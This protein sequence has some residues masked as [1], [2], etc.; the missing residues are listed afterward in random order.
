MNSFSTFPRP[1]VRLSVANGGAS[2]RFDIRALRAGDWPAVNALLK[3]AWFPERSE[4]GWRWLLHG[5]GADPGWILED[6]QGVCGVVGNFLQR[7]H[8]GGETLAAAT[9]HSLVVL[10]RARGGS[11]PLID[12]YSTQ[13]GGRSTFHLNA[14]ALSAPLYRKFG[15]AP[16]PAPTADVKL[17]WHA[18][19]GDLVVERLA[20]K[21]TP[22]SAK[23]GREW[24]AH[25]RYCE[26]TEPLA[27]APQVRGLRPPQ[28]L[29]AMDALFR[30]AVAEG[31]IL[32]ARDADTLAW[33]FSDPDASLP[34][35]ALGWFDG[36]DLAAWVIAQVG[37]TC[38]LDAPSLEIIDL[39][40]LDSAR[41]HALPALVG[42]LRRAC[43]PIGCAR[44]RLNLVAEDLLP[45]LAET[46][47]AIVRRRHPHGHAKLIAADAE[48]LAGWRPTPFDG[49]QGFTMRPPPRPVKVS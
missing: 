27:G 13:G 19:R 35:L 25:R 40:A 9:G 4:A 23:R 36:E 7:F 39:V 32:A 20:W 8:V 48:A 18:R 38:E 21:L 29:P 31:Q 30:A 37:K 10:P 28:C 16:F 49:D 44:L 14:N 43:G 46:E 33:R 15:Y 41:A 45:L 2:L 24:F 22:D 5:S 3:W 47:G 34:P 42:A 26:P 12:A 6:D 17:V 1:N 11:R